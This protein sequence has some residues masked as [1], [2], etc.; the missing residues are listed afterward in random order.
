MVMRTKALGDPNHLGQAWHR[1]ERGAGL[2]NTP[3]PDGS[4]RQQRKKIEIPIT[5]DH[6]YTGRQWKCQWH[7]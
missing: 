1:R 2:I 7:R 6:D 4:V 3:I 5:A